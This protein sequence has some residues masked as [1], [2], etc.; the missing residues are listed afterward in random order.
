MYQ[1][2]SNSFNLLDRFFMKE[3]FYFSKLINFLHLLKE[4][5]IESDLKY[6]LIHLERYEFNEYSKQNL[7]SSFLAITSFLIFQ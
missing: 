7:H 1:T 3:F 2:V 5:K 6:L 4:L